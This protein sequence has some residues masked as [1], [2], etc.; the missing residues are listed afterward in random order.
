MRITKNGAKIADG[1]SH[2]PDDGATTDPKDNDPDVGE[3]GVKVSFTPQDAEDI[4]D[5]EV[6]I[7][8]GVG[9]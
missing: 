6:F 7:E 9:D 3:I 4:T 2:I 1:K 8:G 5:I